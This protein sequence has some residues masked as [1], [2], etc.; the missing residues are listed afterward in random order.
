MKYPPPT[1]FKYINILPLWKRSLINNYK[2]EIS[3][4]ILLYLL[5]QKCNILIASDGSKSERKSRGA[6]LIADLSGNRSISG[7]NPDFGPII[8]MNS[9]QSEI[10]GV[11]STHL[12]LHNYFRYSMTPLTS[13]VNY[14]CDNLEVVNKLK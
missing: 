8:S 1:L 13:H 4:P 9:Y 12:F 10:Y 11:L 14:F 2:D 3:G 5:Q 7:S 6:W